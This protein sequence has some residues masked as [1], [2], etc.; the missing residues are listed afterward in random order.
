[1]KLRLVTFLCAMCGK[2]IAKLIEPRKNRRSCGVKCSGRMGGFKRGE[3]FW[4][5]F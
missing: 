1:M 4:R 5:N 3:N 2:E